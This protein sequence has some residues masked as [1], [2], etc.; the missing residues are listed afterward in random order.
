MC[1]EIAH[2]LFPCARRVLVGH[3]QHPLDQLGN[4]PG[5]PGLFLG[6]DGQNAACGVVA[7]DPTRRRRAVITLQ[8]GFLNRVHVRFLIERTHCLAPLA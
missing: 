6:S 3:G 1:V 5:I 2:R 8:G 4:G 7:G